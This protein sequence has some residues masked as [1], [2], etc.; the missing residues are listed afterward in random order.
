VVYSDSLG[1][2]RESVHIGAAAA[3]PVAARLFFFFFSYST[4]FTMT[5]VFVVRGVCVKPPATTDGG[6]YSKRGYVLCGICAPLTF[7]LVLYY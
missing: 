1:K 2:V 4:R 3:E 7:P 6:S 5:N